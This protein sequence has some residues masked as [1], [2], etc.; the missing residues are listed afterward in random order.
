MQNHHWLEM[1]LERPCLSV[2]EHVGSLYNKGIVLEKMG[3]SSEAAEDKDKAQIIDP[4]Y[5]GGSI[6]KGPAV[7]EL[8]SVI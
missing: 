2:P 8:K 6:N 3:S 5:V 7:S 1:G 4:T